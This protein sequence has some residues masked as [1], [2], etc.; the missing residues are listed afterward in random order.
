MLNLGSSRRTELSRPPGYTDQSLNQPAP[1]AEHVTEATSRDSGTRACSVTTALSPGLP[2]Q[3]TPSPGERTPGSPSADLAHGGV[4]GFV[5]VELVLNQLGQQ[6]VVL[7][8]PA[9]EERHGDGVT[10]L[11]REAGGAGRA[12]GTRVSPALLVYSE[13]RVTY[14]CVIK[15]DKQNQI[16]ISAPGTGTSEKQLAVNSPHQQRVLTTV[17]SP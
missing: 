5:G 1:G 3:G 4:I 11:G 16:L 6:S 7:V 8:L 12:R 13:N 14:A 15:K 10:G 9:E 17:L 2:P